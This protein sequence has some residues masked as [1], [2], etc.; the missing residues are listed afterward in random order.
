MLHPVAALTHIDL[1]KPYWNGQLNSDLSIAGKQ[2]F[3]FGAHNLST[4]DFTRMM[5][6]N[7]QM[8]ADFGLDDLY[9]LVRTGAWTFDK[10]EEMSRT[11]TADLNGDNIMDQNDRF[12]FLAA[13]N[14]VLP[15]FWISGGVRSIKKDNAGV[16]YSAMSD[17]QF[18]SV[19]T[20]IFEITQ[21][22]NSWYGTGAD[23]MDGT[24]ES[25]FEN[26]RGLFLDT[27][28]YFIHRLRAMEIDFGIL[29]YP[30]F[31]ETQA[32]YYS[33][34]EGASAATVPITADGT[35]LERA[36]VILEAMASESLKEVIP[37]YYDVVLSVRAARDEESSEMLDIIFANRVFDLG[38]GLWF[39]DIRNGALAPMFSS[40][41]R[42]I[43][44]R[45]ERLESVIQRLSDNAVAAFELLD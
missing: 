4:Y 43:V 39:G 45:L 40:N 24:F 22:N 25:M 15:N 18:I 21:D 14:Q 26:G 13:H 42:D 32:G 41:T 7:K 30:K 3:A 10:F 8:L 34:I 12:G 31:T 16:P 23:D 20:K 27:T 6:F 33:R 5:L 38:D 28:F 19:F 36:S 17:E 9:E 37:A 11:V 44:S 1:D 29:P 2:F 35:G